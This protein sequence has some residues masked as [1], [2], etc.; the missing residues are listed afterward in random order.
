MIECECF[1]TC[2]DTRVFLVPE[3]DTRPSQ[4]FR[5]PGCSRQLRLDRS[6]PSDESGWLACDDP[7]LLVQRRN[8]RATSRKR[9]L[10]ACACC[11]VAWDWL[12]DPCR[13]ATEVAEHFADGLAT[14]EE[15]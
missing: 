2:C 1:C 3:A 7:A 13:T 14:E 8:S 10:C 6:Q 15:L 5:C 9:R 11:R 12:P 4:V